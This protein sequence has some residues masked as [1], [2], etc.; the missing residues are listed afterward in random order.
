[1]RKQNFDIMGQL[2]ITKVPEKKKEFKQDLLVHI[3]NFQ[4]PNSLG[5]Y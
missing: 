3:T 4:L 1:M 2:I 5:M